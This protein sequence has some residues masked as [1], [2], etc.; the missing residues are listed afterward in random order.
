MDWA[1]EPAG[2]SER[3]L[4]DARL[5]AGE[6]EVVDWQSRCQWNSASA[7]VAAWVRSR[8][9][10]SGERFGVKLQA[11]KPLS[12]ATR[13]QQA[14]RHPSIGMHDHHLPAGHAAT[15][16]TSLGPRAAAGGAV[17]WV[18]AMAA[19][20]GTASSS[21]AGPA[22]S[23][24]PAPVVAAGARLDAQ[25]A[26]QPPAVL[27]GAP[28]TFR[29]ALQAMHIRLSA[30]SFGNWDIAVGNPERKERLAWLARDFHAPAFRQ[31]N[32]VDEAHLRWKSDDGL[33]HL[34]LLV[35]RFPHCR[36]LRDVRAAIVKTGRSNFALPVLTVFRT[37]ARDH[38]LLFAFSETP[39][40]ARVE[41]L[42]KSLPEVLGGEAPCADPRPPRH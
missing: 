13:S 17:L 6:N 33:L 12:A 14:A 24:P 31:A 7:S 34:G 22:V 9:S 8:M 36:Q 21:K 32:R 2:P 37:V 26:T 27:A 11:R 42:W 15:R 20:P 35:L 16:S 19:C 10:P 1:T 25:P 29:D 40:H 39:L 18:A 28:A 4:R 3:R 30:P 23:A 41:A 5:A 38:E